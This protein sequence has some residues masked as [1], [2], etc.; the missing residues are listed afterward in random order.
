MKYFLTLI[1]LTCCFSIQAQEPLTLA[2]AIGLG[3]ER[4]YDIQIERRNV[5]IARNN[6]VWGEA[7]RYPTLDLS[8]GGTFG[9]QNS[10]EV[11]NPFQPVGRTASLGVTPSVNLNWIL[12]DGFRVNISKDRLENL[13]REAQG[14][15]DIVIS[16]TIQA[17]ILAYYRAFL[18]QERLNAFRV[19]RRLSRDKYELLKARQNLGTAATSEL[20]LEEGNY[21][22]DSASVISQELAFRN[23]VRSLNILIDEE[24]IS[25]TYEFS[26]LSAAELNDYEFADL[27]EKMKSR[28]VDLRRQ[29]LSQAVIKNELD[30][31]RSD[32]YPELS[33]NGSY[34]YNK[35]RVDISDLGEPFNLVQEVTPGGDTVFTVKNVRNTASENYGVTLNLSYRLFNGGRINR[36]IQ[37]AIIQ[38]DIGN[39]RLER[40]E[41]SLTRDLYQAFDQ[42]NIRKSLFSVEQRREEVA[43]INLQIS[44]EKYKSGTINSFDFRTVQ[45]NL[46]LATL[47]RLS[48]IY[49]AI[50]S[51]IELMRL[52]G[53]IIDE[54][55]Q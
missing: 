9:G 30:I 20:L 51:K 4:N 33:L 34:S 24:N 49:D 37:N 45:N 6:N 17:I 41:R 1:L 53:G 35:N 31:A 50:E 38:E 42:Y 5:D 13:Q 26:D 44:E 14:N 3:L 18:E 48:A 28:N 19:Q 52:T 16:N 23:A 39:L 55:N 15:A 11:F 40:L 2:E 22:N 29:Y 46:L 25:K 43:K 8:V 10:I 54:Y 32:K 21:L 27:L 36:A 12:F 47:A 7:G